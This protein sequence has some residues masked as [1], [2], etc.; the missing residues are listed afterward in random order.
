MGKVL[1]SLEVIQRDTRER[2]PDSRGADTKVFTNK[3]KDIF[4]TVSYSLSADHKSATD[5]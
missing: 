3:A 1:R 5:Q 4:G 2:V